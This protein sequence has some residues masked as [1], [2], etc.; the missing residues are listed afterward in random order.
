[1]RLISEAVE[2]PKVFAIKLT[3]YRTEKESPIIPL[4]IQAT[5]NGKQAVCVLEPKARFNEERN[6]Q[7]GEMLE[8]AGVHVVYGVIG[9]KTHAKMALVV[10]QERGNLRFY[11]HMSTGN[12]NSETAR[13]YTDMGLL[14][15]NLAIASEVIQIFNYLTGLSYHTKYQKLLVAPVNMKARFMDMIAHEIQMKKAKR[16]AAII[17]KMNSLEDSEVIDMLYQASQAGVSIDLI[18]RGLCCLKPGIKGL[19]ENI[20]V[21]SIVGQFLEHARV[22]YFQNGGKTHLD[23]KF[24][25]GSGDWMYRNLHNRVEV[26]V[27]IEAP[28]LKQECWEIL[29]LQLGDQIQSWGLKADGTYEHLRK[30]TSLT[31]PGVQR[32]LML[33]AQQKGIDERKLYE[34]Q[35]V[36]YQAQS[37]I[38]PKNEKKRR[39]LSSRRL[40]T[41]VS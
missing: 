6:I 21:I 12:Y 10:R 23:G 7:W 31:A 28:Y 39:R 20:R 34:F 38:E 1:M 33:Q 3:L 24:Y 19:S 18:V 36:G 30:S 22:F 29:Q 35:A 15:C 5:R 41:P 13:L 4:L 26:A 9:L 25:I 32:K 11:T 40:E 27:P 14:T 37:R 17:A 16:P 2:D 8:K